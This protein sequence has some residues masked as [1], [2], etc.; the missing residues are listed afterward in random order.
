MFF[1]IHFFIYK[2]FN[3]KDSSAIAV[4]DNCTYSSGYCPFGQLSSA[5]DS[6][7]PAFPFR[8]LLLLSVAGV[9]VAW[10]VFNNALTG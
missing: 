2:V 4:A 7:H 8:S 5:V 9:R 3:Y 10:A 6:S 1:F